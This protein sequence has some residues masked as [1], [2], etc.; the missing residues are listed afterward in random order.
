[1]SRFNFRWYMVKKAQE[2]SISEAARCYGTTRK[3]VRKWVRRYEARGLG[4]LEDV[5]R[6]PHYI[7]HKMCKEDED[8]IVELRGQH[9]K[10]GARR[11]K[12]HYGL[13]GSYTAIHRVLKQGGHVRRK[14]RK[15]KE[16]KDLTE[17]K[18]RLRFCE[19]VQ[20]DTKDLSDI[21]QYWPYLRV[22]KLP[23]YE[24]T[25]RELSTGTA[26]YAYAERNN[27]T[28]A[29]LFAR[30]VAEHLK[31]YGM[32]TTLMGWQTD[33]GSEYIGKSIKRINRQSA[34]EKVLSEHGITHGRIPPRASYLQGDVETFQASV[35]MNYTI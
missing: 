15:H 6:A 9:S 21:Y 19:K 31:S 29:A 10:W 13:V 17:A 22:L 18:K 8:R 35:R 23:R 12:Y 1:M 30:Y 5:S 14:K 27:S 4:G 16:R 3:T 32:D 26:F 24:Y 25:F 7:P 20:V 33:N 2:T 28:Y 11:L 34:F